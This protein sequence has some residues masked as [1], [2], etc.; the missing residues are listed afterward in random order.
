MVTLNIQ[1]DLDLANGARGTITG[2]VLDPNK[3]KF[4]STAPVVRLKR[5]LLYIPVKMSRHTRAMTLPGLEP[6]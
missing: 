4:E 5:L 1:T 3:P 6:D 2:I